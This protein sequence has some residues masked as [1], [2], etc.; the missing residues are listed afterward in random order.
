MF[1]LLTSLYCYSKVN[2]IE[3]WKKFR[4]KHQIIA[5]LKNVFLNVF[6]I[7]LLAI[8]TLIIL[9]YIY[10]FFKIIFAIWFYQN[11]LDKPNIEYLIEKIIKPEYKYLAFF[12]FDNSK[13]IRLLKTIIFVNNIDKMQSIVIYFYMILLFR[14]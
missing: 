14:L 5:H 4:L 10:K 7:V 6:I 11:L 13:T 8:I 2:L 3:K 12:M 1:L 9:K